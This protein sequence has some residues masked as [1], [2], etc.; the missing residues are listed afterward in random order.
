MH[1]PYIKIIQF[2][3]GSSRVQGEGQR[4]DGY[5]L[6]LNNGGGGSDERPFFL[7][8]KEGEIGDNILYGYYFVQ[9]KWRSCA[10]LFIQ[11][12]FVNA[13]LMR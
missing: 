1:K 6:A 10:C 11:V 3:G 13:G 8:H 5:F 7:A 9:K 4:E 12:E 2:S